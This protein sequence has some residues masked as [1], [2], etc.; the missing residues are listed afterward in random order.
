M[1]SSCLQHQSLRLVQRSTH[2]VDTNEH[3]LA[4]LYFKFVY[5]VYRLNLQ[6]K[7]VCNLNPL[8]VITLG[9]LTVLRLQIVFVLLYVADS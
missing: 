3:T 4:F 2:A 9:F 1:Q 7:F 8:I 5:L 6:I